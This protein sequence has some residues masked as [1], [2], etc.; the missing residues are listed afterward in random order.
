MLALTYI[1]DRPTMSQ[2]CHTLMYDRVGVGW[3]IDGH[4]RGWTSIGEGRTGPWRVIEGSL[5]SSLHVSTRPG[6]V[7][8]IP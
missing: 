6:R 1:E 2:S 3:T 8:E 4:L 7:E 5:G